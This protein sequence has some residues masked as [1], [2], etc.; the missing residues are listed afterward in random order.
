VQALDL[1]PPWRETLEALMR[2][3]EDATLDDGCAPT[4]G[5]AVQAVRGAA[6]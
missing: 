4:L 2:D 6:S 1:T 3:H 5:A